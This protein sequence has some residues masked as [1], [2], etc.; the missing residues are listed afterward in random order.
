[1]SVNLSLMFSKRGFIPS[2]TLGEKHAVLELGSRRK[3]VQGAGS[4]RGPCSGMGE[5]ECEATLTGQEGA[6]RDL[7]L[8]AG[9]QTP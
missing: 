6:G 4:H 9:S 7:L 3:A 2:S 5:Q 8:P 1:M